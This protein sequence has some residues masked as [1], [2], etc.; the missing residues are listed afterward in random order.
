MIHSMNPT[1]LAIACLCSAPL[2]P[3]A[4]QTPPVE[5]AQVP[6]ATATARPK[7]VFVDHRDLLGAAVA[8]PATDQADAPAR[9]ATLADLVCDGQGG[10]I[11][12]IVLALP[13]PADAAAGA[14][15]RRHLLPWTQL[16]R[17]AATGALRCGLD[18][19]G[20]AALPVFEPT[21]YGLRRRAAEA[22]GDGAAGTAEA[23][24]KKPAPTVLA[25]ELAA[26]PVFTRVERFGTCSHL[27][28]EVRSGAAAFAIVAI[29]D[30]AG[31]E[32]QHAVPWTAFAVRPRTT[33]APA[34]LRIDRPAGELAA[35]PPLEMEARDLDRQ[36]Y[37]QEVYTFF[38][39]E[40]PGFDERVDLQGK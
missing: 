35:A 4:A 18:A 11:R 22:D 27:A 7:P 13:L 36:P 23:A 38:R 25:S 6:S 3:A 15:P 26:M 8:G 40:T 37:R 24:A 14:E 20:I 32:K 2:F 10:S 34:H 12:G 39:V 17:D 5:R 30:A 16:E 28:I 19:T 21:A 31:T 29:V 9:V 33:G 1:A